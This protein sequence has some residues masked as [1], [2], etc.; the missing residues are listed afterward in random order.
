M[1]KF[2]DAIAKIINALAEATIMAP[3]GKKEE[4]LKKRLDETIVAARN[5]QRAQIYQKNLIPLPLSRHTIIDSN[6]TRKFNR[7]SFNEAEIKAIEARQKEANERASAARS[8]RDLKGT[9]H[10]KAV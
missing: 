1:G 5:A 8:Q 3:G 10:A 2:R 6:R 4:K 7:Y 9:K